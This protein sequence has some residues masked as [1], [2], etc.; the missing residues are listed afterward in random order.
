[1]GN[2]KIV[3]FMDLLKKSTKMFH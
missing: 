3:Y 2:N 1:M